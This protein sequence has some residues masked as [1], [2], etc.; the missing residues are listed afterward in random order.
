MKKTKKQS[1]WKR[2]IISIKDFDRYPELAV[3]HSSK[4]IRYFIT[5]IA[6]FTLFLTITTAVKFTTAMQ[7]TFS[8]IDTKIEN[9]TFKDGILTVPQTEPITLEENEF[10][11]KITIDTTDKDK[12]E[13]LENVK[14]KENT[15][16]ITKDTIFVQNAMTGAT[17]T[18][19]LKDVAKQL[20]A[21]E[22]NKAD[23]MN[24]VNSGNIYAV[25]GTMYLL[26]YFYLFLI[27]LSTVAIDL[28]VLALLG[29]LTSR[30]L[31]IRL[32]FSAT[33]KMAVYALTLPI[34]L[35]LVYVVVN[36]FTGFTIEYF[37]VMYTAISY[38]YMITAILLM[39]SDMMRR[40][41]ELTKI[42]E[43]Q[44][45]LHPEIEP[46]VEN[47]DKEEKK[48]K[49]EKKPEK[50]KEKEGTLGEEPEGNHA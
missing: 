2:M 4:A 1:F 22:F 43:E 19:S 32:K 16:L 35:N 6:L 24:F 31:G 46:E 28:I 47:P 3:E 49:K 34:L 26:V 18:Y 39:K 40:Q 25:Y 17:V 48:E 12:T 8:Q 44:K 50:P 27:Y 9:F 38:I 41:E 14:Q 42:V 30:I 13:Q 37:Q 7:K 10:I 33:C 23:F 15:I 29:F 45:R 36:A 20:P 5:L 21:G 11:G